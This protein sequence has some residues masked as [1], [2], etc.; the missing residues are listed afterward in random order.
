MLQ[1]GGVVCDCVNYHKINLNV[2]YFSSLLKTNYVGE[3]GLLKTNYVGEC[4]LS[5]IY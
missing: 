2:L 4:Y 5:M 3:C 1:I